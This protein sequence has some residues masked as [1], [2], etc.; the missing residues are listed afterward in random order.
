VWE[1]GADIYEI[2]N[3]LEKLVLIFTRSRVGWARDMMESAV[4]EGNYEGVEE[5]NK[6]WVLNKN[7]SK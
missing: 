5:I 6:A 7:K 2:E 3:E 1:V 4:I